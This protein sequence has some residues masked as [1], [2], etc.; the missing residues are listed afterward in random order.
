MIEY[1]GNYAMLVLS[2]KDSEAV[3]ITHPDG[4]RI[5]VIIAETH[6]G[7]AKLVINAPKHIRIIRKEIEGEEKNG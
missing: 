1:Q 7:R 5:E 6:N 2:R 3:I 4:T